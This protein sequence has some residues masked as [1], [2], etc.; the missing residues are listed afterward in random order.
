[1]NFDEIIDRKN[2]GALKWDDPYNVAGTEDILP[3]WVADMDF[4]APP[5][6]LAAIRERAEHPVFGYTNPPKDYLEIIAAWYRSRY[7][8]EVQAGDFLIAPGVVPS[9]GIAIRSLTSVGAGVL[10]LTPVY[11]PFYEVVRDNDRTLVTAALRKDS[12]GRYRI[13]FRAI[14]EALINAKS[15]GVKVETLLFCSPHNPGGRVWSPEELKEILEFCHRQNIALV[16]DEIHADI[17]VGDKPFTSLAGADSGGGPAIVTLGAPNKTF[18]LAGLHISHF[19]VRDGSA[20]DRIKRGIAAAGYSQPNIF[21]AVAAR[22]AYLHGEPWLE[23]LNAYLKANI[24]FAEDFIVSRIEGV[25]VIRPEGG[26]LVWL[27]ASAL[28]R[29]M[30]LK[31][32]YELV[33]KLAKEGRVRLSHG[34]KFGPEGSGHLR[35]NVACPRAQLREGLER[36]AHWVMENSIPHS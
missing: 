16:S 6:V 15:E 29:K 23:A 19:V 35:L 2:T 33:S 7:R 27:E 8:T 13:D 30:G 10:V 36:W 4:A 9:L 5:E 17:L 3:F 25:E 28:I 18:N 14:D 11:Y 26:Y 34:S 31:S 24:D 22:A 32:D 20:R 12:G 21:S 1:M